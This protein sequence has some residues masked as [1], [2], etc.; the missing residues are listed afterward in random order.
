MTISKVR[1]RKS[2]RSPR[3]VQFNL[4][5]SKRML[6]DIEIEAERLGKPIGWVIKKSWD[7]ARPLIH[8]LG[9]EAD[10]K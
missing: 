6:R 7:L 8:E 3:L 2:I 9:R 5:L 1:L 10:P 4:Y